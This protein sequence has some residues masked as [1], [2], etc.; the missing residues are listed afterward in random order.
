MD[1]PINNIGHLVLLGGHEMNMLTYLSIR[2]MI[3]CV[4]AD[5][6]Y[7]YIDVEPKGNLHYLYKSM[8]RR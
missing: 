5:A 1:D 2:S 4:G 7:I 3:H 8:I 6:M